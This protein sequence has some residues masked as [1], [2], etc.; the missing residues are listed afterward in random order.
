[1]LKE[2]PQGGQPQ[3][4]GGVPQAKQ[5]DLVE[6]DQKEKTTCPRRRPC[7]SCTTPHYLPLVV[8]DT[9][10]FFLCL[11][12]V[13]IQR[14]WDAIYLYA[15]SAA[16]AAT[17]THTHTYTNMHTYATLHLPLGQFAD[18]TCMEMTSQGGGVWLASGHSALSTSLLCSTQ[19]HLI[20]CRLCQFDCVS[21][22]AAKVIHRGLES[23]REPMVD[24]ANGSRRRGS[25]L[26]LSL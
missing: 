16:A 14:T 12:T 2:P 11:A 5:P 24:S 8:V 18:V 15:A 6:R 21:S 22:Q 17:H 10:L 7:S 26:Q 9:H 25:D 19:L 4:Q 20:D 13:V 1:M 23:V 3:E